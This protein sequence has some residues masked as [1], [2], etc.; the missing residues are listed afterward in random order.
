VLSM[1]VFASEMRLRYAGRLHSNDQ[2]QRLLLANFLAQ[3]MSW[4]SKQISMFNMSMVK[5]KT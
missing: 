2:E 3:Q 4:K 5:R 1:S